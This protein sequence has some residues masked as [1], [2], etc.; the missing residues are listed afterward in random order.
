MRPEDEEIPVEEIARITHEAHRAL[1][2]WLED[3]CPSQPWDTLDP[4]HQETVINRVRLIQRGFPY[5]YVHQIWVDKMSSQGWTHGDAKDPYGKRHPCM[6]PFSELSFWDQQK[7]VLAF[8]VV[9]GVTSR[10]R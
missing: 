9:Q 5:D 8:H 3:V 7:V 6:L 1:Q 10:G 4:D 2:V